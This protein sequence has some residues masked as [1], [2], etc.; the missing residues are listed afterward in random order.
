[1]GCS[2]QW[3]TVLQQGRMRGGSGFMDPMVGNGNGDIDP[4]LISDTH[5]FFPT[6]SYIQRNLVPDAPLLLDFPII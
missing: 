3:I 5:Q 4:F 6:C 1:M 2:W